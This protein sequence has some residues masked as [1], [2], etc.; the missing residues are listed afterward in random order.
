MNNVSCP[1]LGF[2]GY[3]GSGKTTVL[4]Q[5]IPILQDRGYRIGVIK[6]AHHQFDIDH[7]GK[8][9]YELRQAG[10]RQM[11][12]ASQHRWALISETPDRQH[13]PQLAEL[14]LKL[15]SNELDIIL[16]EGFKHQ[17]LPKIEVYRPA[18]SHHPLYPDDP[19]IIALLTELPFEA[20]RDLT[21]LDINNPQELA[22]F[23]ESFLQQPPC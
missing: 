21:L 16:V 12:V 19:D 6:H 1:I 2:I 5:L 7:P 9:S 23:A 11:L 18:L 13:E 22:D 8:D 15:D 17:T 4:T 14:L 10:A 20:E 3:S